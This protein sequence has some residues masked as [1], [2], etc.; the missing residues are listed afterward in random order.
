MACVDSLAVSMLF[1][2]E[3]TVP[4]EERA[5]QVKAREKAKALNPFNIEKERKK[6][7]SKEKGE[8]AKPA[9]N[10]AI[11]RGE[12]QVEGSFAEMAAAKKP[13]RKLDVSPTPWPPPA[14][15]YLDHVL[16]QRG[17]LNPRLVL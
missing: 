4:D 11:E 1:D 12:A 16:V 7:E 5:G 9:W 8:R 13:R 3:L 15:T 17:L 14:A 10:P 6:R 2:P